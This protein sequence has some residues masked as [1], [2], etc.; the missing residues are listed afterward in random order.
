[1]SSLAASGTLLATARVSSFAAS[2]TLLA[3]ARVSSLAAVPAPAAEADVLATEAPE[4]IM[5]VHAAISV[6]VSATL[7]AVRASAGRTLCRFVRGLV[8]VF[9][10]IAHATV[11][12][13]GSYATAPE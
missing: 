11:A 12:A 3:T 6:I 4:A 1:V 5:L 8:H 7:A 13:S 10:T 9:V 2:G